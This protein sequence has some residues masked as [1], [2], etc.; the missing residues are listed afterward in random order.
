MLT[1]FPGR[2]TRCII[3][4]SLSCGS[5]GRNC[6]RE[7]GDGSRTRWFIPRIRCP[8]RV[9]QDVSSPPPTGWLPAI[10]SLRRSATPSARRSSATPPLCMACGRRRKRRCAGSTR[11]PWTIPAAVR[12]S[13]GLSSIAACTHVA[14]ARPGPGLAALQVRDHVR[15][16]G[17]EPRVVHDFAVAG[18]EEAGNPTSTPTSRPVAGSG[19]G[20]VSAT[21]MTY[22]RQCSRL[23]WSALLRARRVGAEHVGSSH[24]HRVSVVDMGYGSGGCRLAE[25]FA[26]RP[27]GPVPTFQG[28]HSERRER[29][30]TF[31]LQAGAP[32]AHL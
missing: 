32:A 12:H 3:R 20:S 7:R 13:A 22:Q 11:E 27:Y 1:S 6:S 17:Q 30:F 2:Q 4:I 21:R 18:G 19:A 31:S 5:R 14:G 25:L 9:E 26:C 28:R 16:R 10:I 8:R 24:L 29:G 15:R 23:S